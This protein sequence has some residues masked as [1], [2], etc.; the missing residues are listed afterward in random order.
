M[1]HSQRRRVP[2][3]MA[4]QHPDNAY[5]P[6]WSNKPFI[7][8]S[9]EVEE[10][11]RSFSDLGCQ[12]YMWDWEGKFVDEAVVDRIYLRYF[13]YFAKHP[14]GQEKFLPFRVPNIQR[15][16]QAR[17]ARA[18]A[19]ILSAA[20]SARELK[21]DSP[22]LFEVIHPMTGSA[23]ELVT[24]QRKLHETAQFQQKILESKH[25]KPQHLDIIPLIV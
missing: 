7:S 20:Y 17:L 6:Y 15:E 25:L 21:L 1:V 23:E 18:F 19:G 16:G 10:C 3:T 13:D 9:K 22:P 12:E 2:A 8:T 4:T 5:K 11:Y 14:L 24:L